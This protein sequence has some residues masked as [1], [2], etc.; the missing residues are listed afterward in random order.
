VVLFPILPRYPAR[1]LTQHHHDEEDTLVG[2]QVERHA[3]GTI[4]KFVNIFN[5]TGFLQ[6]TTSR[7]PL[8]T[9][10]CTQASAVSRRGEKSAS[11]M[12]ARKD[13]GPYCVA[14][15]SHGERCA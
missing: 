7:A 6:R 4:L 10:I 8:A 1:T 5:G 15:N 11:K 14:A 13:R 3:S 9:F 2:N 12:T